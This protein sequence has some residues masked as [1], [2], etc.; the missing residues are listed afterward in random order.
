M[1]GEKIQLIFGLAEL[2]R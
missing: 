1:A 2:S